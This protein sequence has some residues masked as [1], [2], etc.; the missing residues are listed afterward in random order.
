M[1]NLWQK[2]ENRKK[3]LI[4]S[5]CGKLKEAEDDC[6]WRTVNGT[7]VCFK[8][9]EDPKDSIDKAFSG[10][11]D[12]GTKDVQIDKKKISD[13]SD[14]ADSFRDSLRHREDLY[15]PE[16]ELKNNAIDSQQ[17]YVKRTVDGLDKISGKG[18]LDDIPENERRWELIKDNNPQLKTELATLQS[19]LDTNVNKPYQQT[20]EKA[21]S[22]YRGA[23]ANELT[24]ILA[25]GKVGNGDDG[26]NF[27]SSTLDI[28]TAA[29]FNTETIIEFEGQSVRDSGGELVKYSVEPTP[30][31]TY[32]YKSNVEMISKPMPAKFADESEVRIPEGKNI[33]IKQVILSKQVGNFDKITA[34]LDKSGIKYH[35][36]QNTVD[37]DQYIKGLKR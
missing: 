8:D 32:D 26:Y 14:K 2:Q 31:S 17:E 13:I 35:V 25:S 33:T 24:N 28:E 29:Q 1:H 22:I 3:K 30:Y 36:V 15:V 12:K 11:G 21:D 20:Y 9:G 37:R 5:K 4:C 27:V 18:A 7:P 34:S 16:K 10:K 23:N 6:N 19:E